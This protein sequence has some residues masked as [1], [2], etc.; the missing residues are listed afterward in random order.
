MNE[1]AGQI[2]EEERRIAAD[3][4]AVFSTPQGQ[5]VLDH[6]MKKIFLV[7][8]IAGP[9]DGNRAVYI[10]AVHDCAIKVRLLLNREFV[11]RKPPQVTTRPSRFTTTAQQ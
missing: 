10:S 9:G 2:A 6:L 4:E 11:M 3:F 8:A 5:R 1:N 7:D